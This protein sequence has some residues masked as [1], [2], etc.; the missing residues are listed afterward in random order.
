[1]IDKGYFLGREGNQLAYVLNRVSPKK[2]VLLMVHGFAG[3]K[4]ENGLFV[5]SS[6]F[7]EKRGYNVFR[8][9][10]TGVGE[11]KGEF[12]H[13]SLEKQISDLSRALGYIKQE[14]YPRIGLIGFSLGA[15][16]SLLNNPEG[17]DALALWSPALFPSRDMFPRYDTEEVRRELLER[18]YIPKSGLKVGPAIINDLRTC[19]LVPAMKSVQKPVLLVH[20][21]EDSRIDYRNTQSAIGY[22]PNASLQLINGANHSYKGNLVH[23]LEVLTKTC[24][25][26]DKQLSQ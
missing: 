12:M 8:F 19:D 26:F 10:M 25:W 7:F 16:I 15:T 13:T 11:S 3:N 17:V 6:T 2:P 23:R 5:D 1:M 14:R 18:G 21:T 9:D 20:G 24:D 4:D 22:F